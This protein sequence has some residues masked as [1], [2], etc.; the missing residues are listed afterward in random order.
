MTLGAQRK[1]AHGNEVDKG[2]W[3]VEGGSRLEHWR[4]QSQSL[5]ENLKSTKPLYGKFDEVVDA[6]VQERP[7]PEDEAGILQK[8]T[9]RGYGNKKRGQTSELE[10]PRPRTIGCTEASG[11]FPDGF[12]RTVL[13]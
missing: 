13:L 12:H 4:G 6:L 3:L 7:T 5:D 11:S 8:K 9:G 2:Q 1:G 10:A